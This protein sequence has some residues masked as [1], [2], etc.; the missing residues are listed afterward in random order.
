MKRPNPTHSSYLTTICSLLL[1]SSPASLINT[2]MLFLLSPKHQPCSQQRVDKLIYTKRW[3]NLGCLLVDH[4][5]PAGSHSREYKPVE[6]ARQ[7]WGVSLLLISGGWKGP[8][9]CTAFFFFLLQVIFHWN[10]YVLFEPQA[11]C[12]TRAVSG[13]GSRSVDCDAEAD[14]DFRGPRSTFPLKGPMG[15]VYQ[16]HFCAF[17]RHHPRSASLWYLG[18]SYF[19]RS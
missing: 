14:S 9:I 10:K 19:L 3:F 12:F 6:E 8:P 1:V 5:A 16:E 11:E 17:S 4:P 7:Y 15:A 18:L 13:L 2:F